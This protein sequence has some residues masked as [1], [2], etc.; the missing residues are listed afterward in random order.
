MAI[1]NFVKESLLLTPEVEC[2]CII[3]KPSDGISADEAKNDLRQWA[4]IPVQTHS[5][6]IGVMTKSEEIFDDTDALITF[7]KG[8]PV[9]VVTADCV[10]ILLYAPDI[11]GVA[12]VHAGW[13]GSLGGIV[14]KALDVMVD[15]G[16]DLS[17]LVVVY[18]PSISMLNYEVDWELGE[19]F[20]QAGFRDY[21]YYL[22]GSGEKPHIDLQGV[23]MERLMG[24]GVKK[25][26][27]YLNDFC[28][29]GS[30][31]PNDSSQSRYHS[32]RRDGDR[33]GR[34][35]TAITIL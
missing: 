28:T 18:G 19:R 24:R 23:N 4:D 10:P 2:F 29:L 16:A 15:R 5:L 13:K 35:L 17:K 12:A 7:E 21:V 1:R 6:N 3:P 27:I 33:S 22:H 20:R 25:E 34:Q 11:R 8:I 30:R 32:Y 14:D 31:D 9:G 26:N